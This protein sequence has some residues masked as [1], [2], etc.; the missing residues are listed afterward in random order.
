MRFPSAVQGVLA[1]DSPVEIA[2]S[3]MFFKEEKHISIGAET[4]S[5]SEDK[6][7]VNYLFKNNATTDIV[8][9]IAFP[10]PNYGFYPLESISYPLYDARR[11]T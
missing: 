10:M 1:I 2:A 11:K 7:E 4:L 5:L 8:T 9:G 6:I 3:G